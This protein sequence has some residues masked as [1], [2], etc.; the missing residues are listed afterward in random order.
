[1]NIKKAISRLGWRLGEPKNF[2]PNKTD[3]EAVNTIIEWEEQQRVISLQ[4]NLLFGK[5]FC[6]YFY[7]NVK[8]FGLESLNK[9]S[10]KDLNQMLSLPME[11]F[12]E[13]LSSRLNQLHRE[14]VIESNGIEL[15]TGAL[16][17]EDLL[18]LDNLEGDLNDAWTVDQV[19]EKINEMITDSLN[20]YS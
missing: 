7:Q 15:T 9:A 20:T 3:L 13:S 11:K 18:K 6:Y 5:L 12:Y 17:D 1:M 8:Y 2:T 4:D 10:S 19:K 14:A 16:S